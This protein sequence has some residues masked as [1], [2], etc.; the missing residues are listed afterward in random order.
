M[1][2]GF[3]AAL[4]AMA[5]LPT[6]GDLPS[7]AEIAHVNEVAKASFAPGKGKVDD[8]GRQI[9]TKEEIAAIVASVTR[10]APS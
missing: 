4:E 5:H 2:D 3:A 8:K 6:K 7:Q 1:A 9:P 10:K